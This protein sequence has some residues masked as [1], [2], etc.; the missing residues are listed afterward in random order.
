MPRTT[1]LTCPHCHTSYEET[2]IVN[3]VERQVRCNECHTQIS[4][5][6]GAHCVWCAYGDTPCYIV[7]NQASCNPV[8]LRID[9]SDG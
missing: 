7:Q 1:L 4:A 3:R 8:T 2:M 6:D 5:P 9:H